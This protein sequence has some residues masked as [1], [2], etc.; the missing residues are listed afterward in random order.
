MSFSRQAEE[1]GGQV[2]AVAAVAA[3]APIL[4][5]IV[6]VENAFRQDAAYPVASSVVETAIKIGS[7]IGKFA[8][9]EGPNLVARMMIGDA[10]CIVLPLTGKDDYSCE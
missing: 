4:G 8:V 10:L 9:R 7:A 2:G 1:I 5:G 3:V 6:M